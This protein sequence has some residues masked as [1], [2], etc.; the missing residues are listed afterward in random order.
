MGEEENEGEN[1]NEN[2]N[3]NKADEDDK[4]YRVEISFSPGMNPLRVGQDNENGEEEGEEDKDNS[5]SIQPL[6]VLS[7][8]QMTLRD[9]K[10]LLG[11]S[12]AQ[13]AELQMPVE[14]SR[15]MR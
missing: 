14:W 10:E 15:R 7:P 6:F 9:F 12:L 1:E 8:P 4:R 2:E 5:E 3:E 11:A 13:V